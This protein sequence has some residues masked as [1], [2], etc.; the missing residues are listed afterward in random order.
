MKALRSKKWVAT[1]FTVV[2]AVALSLYP[3]EASTINTI[4]GLVAAYV[5]GQ[6]YVDGKLV[7]KGVK[8]E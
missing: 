1:I 7:D 2:V 5:L 6:S 4:A 3:H 8:T